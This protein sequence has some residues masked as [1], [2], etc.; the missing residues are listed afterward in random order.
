MNNK[1]SVIVADA[2]YIDKAAFNLTVNFERMLGRRIPPADMARWA[3]CIALD[4]G[5]RNGDNHVHLI[6]IHDRHTGKLE[7]FVPSLLK[8]ELAGKAFK[9]TLGE[10]TLSAVST[11]SIVNKQ[12]LFADTLRFICSDPDVIRLMVVPNTE[13]AATLL[14]VTTILREADDDNRRTTLFAMQPLPVASVRT[15]ILGYSL[16]SALGIKGEELRDISNGELRVEN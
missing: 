11:E 8:E 16:M 4:G 7:N 10:F 1:R 13:D 12:Q 9:S 15:E 14:Q 6:L 3:E 5:V 2:D